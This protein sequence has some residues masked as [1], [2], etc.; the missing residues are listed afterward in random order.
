M[1]FS[2]PPEV[3]VKNSEKTLILTLEYKDYIYE[4]VDANIVNERLPVRHA[5]S[6]EAEL[7]RF[8]IKSSKGDVLGGGEISKPNILRGVLSENNQDLSHSEESLSQA[9]FVVRYP[10]VE[11]MKV[12]GIIDGNNANQARSGRSLSQPA[13][14]SN[15]LDFSKML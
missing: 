14:N 7:L 9:T 4:V 13:S 1:T 5:N 2:A 8:H 11:G 10:F 15:D 12:L 3:N 6:H